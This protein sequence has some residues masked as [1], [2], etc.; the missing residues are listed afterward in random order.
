MRSAVCYAAAALSHQHDPDQVAQAVGESLVSEFV[1]H[2][3]TLGHR[4]YQTAP[5]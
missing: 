1:A 5:T 4:H 3:T 2:P